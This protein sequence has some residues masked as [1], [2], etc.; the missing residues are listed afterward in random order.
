MTRTH[1]IPVALGLEGCGSNRNAQNVELLCIDAFPGI[2][3]YHG[4]GQLQPEQ[5]ASQYGNRRPVTDAQFEFAVQVDGVFATQDTG[6]LRELSQMTDAPLPWIPAPVVRWLQ[7]RPDAVTGLGRL[8]DLALAAIR[9]GS[10]TPC[11]IF[12]SVAASDTPPQFWG[13]TTL[14]AKVDALA[15]REPPLVKIDGPADRLPQWDSDV[16][17]GEFRIQ[18]LPNQPLHAKDADQATSPC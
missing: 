17:L 2:E 14:W 1:L 6:V 9:A 18:A 15:E 12:A 7:E 13:D 10:D 5:P 4:L 8:E 16:P 3:P 11:K